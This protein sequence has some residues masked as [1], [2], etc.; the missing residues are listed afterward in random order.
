MTIKSL[1]VAVS[2]M[3][4]AIV[5]A[6]GKKPVVVEKPATERVVNIVFIGNSITAG[7]TLQDRANQ[8]PPA[9]VKQELSK[10]FGEGTIE[11]ANVAVSGS[12]T[13]DWQPGGKMFSSAVK[14]A[15]AFLADKGA[16][17]V[18]SISL[19]TNDS[20]VRGVNGSALSNEDFRK[21]LTVIV[22]SLLSRYPLAEVLLNTPIWY[23]QNVYNSAE[24]L[25]EGQR[26]LKSYIGDISEVVSNYRKNRVTRVHLGEDHWDYFDAD[27]SLFTPE[28][29]KA[30]AFYLHPNKN[31]AAKLGSFWA[32][33]LASII[34]GARPVHVNL[35]SG[36]ELLVYPSETGKA[37]KAIVICPGGGYTY[38]A[39]DKEGM[40][41]G[42]WISARGVTA[43]VLFYRLP[44]G[45]KEVPK[46]DAIEAMEYVRAHSQ[47]YGGYTKVGIM[48]SSAGGHLASTIATHTELADFQVLLYP[49]ITMKDGL[50]HAGSRSNLLG[51]NPSAETENEFSNEMHVTKKTPRALIVLSM[52]DKVVLPRPNGIAYA[53]ALLDNEVETTLLCY[54]SGGHGWCFRETFEFKDEWRQTLDKF[55][56]KK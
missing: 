25:V 43:C 13:T 28:R 26:R 47:E 49:V 54:P 21:N 46:T 39:K 32:S 37:E 17:L 33:E 18:F 27:A 52:N 23:S 35:K 50:T 4:S 38:L 44:K 8:A 15:D 30:G 53:A 12:T 31:G 34:K 48:G 16:T 51:E 6:A 11:I 9:V 40:E 56:K 22:D 42:K 45:D 29:G 55:L 2:L 1:I 14:A 10:T 41:L 3:A 20:A 36:A 5:S 19:G 24:Y 7:A